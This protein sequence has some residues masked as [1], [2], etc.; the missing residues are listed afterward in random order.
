MP[1]RYRWRRKPAHRI[2]RQSAA[3]Q[4]PNR[5]AANGLPPF[6]SARCDAEHED[7]Q[8]VHSPQFQGAV[9]VLHQERS[10]DRWAV[11]C[12]KMAIVSCLQATA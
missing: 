8:A 2:D 6:W 4:G 5:P 1:V 10:I 9:E 3:R 11:L 7:G 12:S